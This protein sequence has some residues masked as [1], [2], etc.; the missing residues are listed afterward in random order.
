[1][2]NV[3]TLILHVSSPLIIIW[4][5]NTL[6]NTGIPFSFKTWFAGLALIYVVRY[7]VRPSDRY[8][9]IPFDDEWDDDDDDEDED[10]DEQGDEHKAD[11]YK[12]FSEKLNSHNT[13]PQGTGKKERKTG[14]GKT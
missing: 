9:Y 5:L 12:I 3:F 2:L 6:F 11:Y 8:K 10:A 7:H 14:K 13:D 4:S 1:M